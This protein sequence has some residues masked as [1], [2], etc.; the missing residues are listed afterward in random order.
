MAIKVLQYLM[1]TKQWGIVLGRENHPFQIK[2]D[3]R[4]EKGQ[5]KFIDVNEALCG[6]DLPAQAFCDA[7]HAT[8]IDDKK[9]VSGQLLHVFT[10]PVFWNSSVQSLTATSSTESEVRA[11]SEMTQNVLFLQKILTHFNMPVEPFPIKIDSKGARDVVTHYAHTPHSRHLE[12]KHDF[13]RDH[14]QLAEVDY[15]LIP[16][17]YNPADLFTK[18]LPKPKFLM[19]RQLIGMAELPLHLQTAV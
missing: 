8:G 4:A 15:I 12:V 18:A 7:N 13:M 16:G 19:F 17:K 9:S 14:Y 11:A 2:D 1:G 6:Y 5:V 10:G 3:H